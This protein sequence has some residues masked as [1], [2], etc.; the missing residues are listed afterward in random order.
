MK[1]FIS[2]LLAAATL[3]LGLAASAQ[4]IVRG[5]AQALGGRKWIATGAAVGRECRFIRPDPQPRR[6]LAQACRNHRRRLCPKS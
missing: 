5:L 3:I 4:Q 6:M 1:S 2:T